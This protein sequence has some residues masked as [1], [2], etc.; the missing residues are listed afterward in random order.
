MTVS[1][2]VE[3]VEEVTATVGEV[4]EVTAVV[5][6]PEDSITATVGDC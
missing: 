4:A 3:E 5:T 1:A 2:E 6:D